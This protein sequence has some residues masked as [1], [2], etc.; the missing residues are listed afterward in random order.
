MGDAADEFGDWLSQNEIGFD[1]PTTQHKRRMSSKG[2][3]LQQKSKDPRANWPEDL[4]SF[5][6]NYSAFFKLESVKSYPAA[7]V[8][9]FSFDKEKPGIYSRTE[10]ATILSRYGVV[11]SVYSDTSFGSKMWLKVEFPSTGAVFEQ[12][13][14]KVK[15]EKK[16]NEDTEFYLALLQSAGVK[17]V[18]VCL[19]KRSYNYLCAIS[20]SEGQHVVIQARDLFM[21]GVVEDVLEEWDMDIVEQFAG[22]LKWVINT[23]DVSNAQLY[24]DQKKQ[25]FRDLRQSRLVQKAKTFAGNANL[26]FNGLVQKAQNSLA[27]EHSDAVYETP[28]SAPFA[29]F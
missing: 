10:I 25:V 19:D 8:A 22:D 26:D 21:V 29:E 18:E 15:V 28:P 17:M 13:K 12:N 11:G 1:G 23:V 9:K 2:P 20:V 14:P 24:A 3:N 16:M 27:I 4:K 5:V 7:C 6:E